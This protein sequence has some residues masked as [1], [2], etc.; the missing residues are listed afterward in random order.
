MSVNYA[1]LYLEINLIAVVMTA[2]ILVKTSG[3]SRMTAQKYFARAVYSE[4]FFCIS[5]TLFVMYLRG[6]FS[7]NSFWILFWKTL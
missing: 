4:M 3:I 7:P 1:L 6:I 2:I 5:D